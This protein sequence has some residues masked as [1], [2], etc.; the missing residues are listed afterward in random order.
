MHV[1]VGMLLD[2][3]VNEGVLK[4]MQVMEGMLLDGRVKEGVLVDR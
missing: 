4:D 2:G 1:M 3:R